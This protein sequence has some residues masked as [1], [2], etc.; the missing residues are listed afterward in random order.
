MGKIASKVTCLLNYLDLVLPIKEASNGLLLANSF[1]A[2]AT[3]S[4]EPG[5]GTLVAFFIFCAVASAR[6]LYRSVFFIEIP[7]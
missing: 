6:F 4:A 3:S 5:L 7:L 1:L 2:L